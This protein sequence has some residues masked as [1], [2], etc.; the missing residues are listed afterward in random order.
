MDVGTTIT[1]ILATLG[2]SVNARRT[3]FSHVLY[4]LWTAI[5]AFILITPYTWIWE[6]IAPGELIQNAE[7]ALV[8][9]HTCFN[10]VGVT[11]IVPFTRQFARLITWLI[12]SQGITYT[13]GLSEEFLANPTLALN[14]VQASI[15]SEVITL[16]HHV[17]AILGAPDGKRVELIE[18]QTALDETHTYLDQIHLKAEDGTN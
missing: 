13:D 11:S 17:E 4:N 12:P 9:F 7:I 14:A 3:G 18:L 10:V 2:G 5:L 1:A 8:A 16:L 6:R 15:Q